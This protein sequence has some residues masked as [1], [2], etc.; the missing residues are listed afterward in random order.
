MLH[1]EWTN[2]TEFLNTQSWE[3]ISPFRSHF[4]LHAMSFVE[5]FMASN[6]T[7]CKKCKLCLPFTGYKT[8]ICKELCVV[9]GSLR[10]VLCS[11]WWSTARF[12]MNCTAFYIH[13]LLPRMKK[14]SREIVL[15]LSVNLHLD[16]L[17]QHDVIRNT[18]QVCDDLERRILFVSFKTQ[19]NSW[20]E[21]LVTENE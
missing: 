19:D 6:T 10:S 15:V 1:L 18:G 8:P 9:L 17:Q 21:K 13:L 16:P 11:A 12:C 14:S 7:F 2:K 20:R 5:S 4:S 3:P